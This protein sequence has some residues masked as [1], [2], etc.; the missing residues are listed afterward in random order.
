LSNFVTCGRGKGIATYF[1]SEFKVEDI[2]SNPQYQI[3]KITSADMDILNVYRSNNASSTFIDDLRDMLTEIIVKTTILC[4][5]LNFCANKH[6]QHPIKAFL[7]KL[8]FVQL[9]EKPT[10]IV[11]DHVYLLCKEPET[12]ETKIK[13][14]YYSD[15]DKNVI[16]FK[17]Q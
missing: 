12:V 7:E 9:I 11:L 15:H 10:H 4:G 14:C 17:K 3:T 2:I 8:K 16:T 5:D 1:T 6:P 13:G